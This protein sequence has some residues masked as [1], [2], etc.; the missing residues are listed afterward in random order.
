MVVMG[1]YTEIKVECDVRADGDVLTALQIMFGDLDDSAVD[2]GDLGHRIGAR[3]FH[4]DRWTMIGRCGSAYFDAEP[5]SSLE[6]VA[7]TAGMSGDDDVWRIRSIS[8]LKNYDGEIGHFFAWLR[9]MVVG[10]SGQV[11][12]HEWYEEDEEPTPVV[13]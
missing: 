12:G 3:L 4:C 7:N 9:P 13:L 2:L 8:N 1:M 10:K 6:R 11:I 5:S